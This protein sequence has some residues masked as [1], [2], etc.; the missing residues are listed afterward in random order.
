M[1]NAKQKCKK[2]MGRVGN[3][4][5]RPTKHIENLVVFIIRFPTYR[6]DAFKSSQYIRIKNPLHKQSENACMCFKTR[7]V[8]IC[9][10]MVL[11]LYYISQINQTLRIQLDGNAIFDFLHIETTCIEN[12]VK[13]KSYARNDQ[14]IT[15][16]EI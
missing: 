3:F 11:K 5:P 16:Q 6:R 12:S 15:I 7:L 1:K 13:L 2:R 14:N 4:S 8:R 10:F 9:D